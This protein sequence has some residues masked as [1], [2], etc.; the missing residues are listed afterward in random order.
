MLGR[1]HMDVNSCLDAHSKISEEIF[2]QK[3]RSKLDIL[4]KAAG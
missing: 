1:L 4:R 3:K 2:R